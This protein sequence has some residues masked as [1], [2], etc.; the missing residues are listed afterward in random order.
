MMAVA[1]ARG[2]PA[3]QRFPQSLGGFQAAQETRF[4]LPDRTMIRH[5]PHSGTVTATSLGVHGATARGCLI[6]SAS[7]PLPVAAGFLGTGS[8]AVNLASVAPP[9]DKNLTIATSAEKNPARYFINTCVGACQTLA[10]WSSAL[11]SS[12]NIGRSASWFG[13]SATVISATTGFRG[14][15]IRPS[16]DFGSAGSCRKGSPA[17]SASGRRGRE[18]AVYARIFTAIDTCGL[19]PP[20]CPS[21]AP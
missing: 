14:Q 7:F 6:A 21:T 9:T 17:P 8:H 12:S 5:A 2:R 19:L 1:V 18:R 15:P 13:P 4:M 16:P 11:A 20:S 10:I 3:G